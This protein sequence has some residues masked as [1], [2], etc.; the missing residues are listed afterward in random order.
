MIVQVV[1]V[2]HIAIIEAAVSVEVDVRR[3]VVG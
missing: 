1:L 3:C 2:W